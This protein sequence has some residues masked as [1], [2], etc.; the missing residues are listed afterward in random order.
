MVPSIKL[1]LAHTRPVS[2]VVALVLR[3]GSCIVPVTSHARISSPKP[4]TQLDP[5]V[6]CRFCRAQ[7][8]VLVFR[9]YAA[10]VPHTSTNILTIVHA[11]NLL[12]QWHSGNNPIVFPYG[13]RTGEAKRCPRSHSILRT[14]QIAIVC[15]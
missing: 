3:A 15:L 5:L 8:F 11:T 13:R 1:G 10:P 4:R 7:L 6:C 2:D 12:G 14:V 9:L